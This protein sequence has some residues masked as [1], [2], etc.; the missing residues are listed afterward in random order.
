LSPGSLRR[1][2]DGA[3]DHIFRRCTES[4]LAALRHHQKVIIFWEA[5]AIGAG[6]ADAVFEL[7]S[8]I[9]HENPELLRGILVLSHFLE[10]RVFVRAEMKIRRRHPAGHWSGSHIDDAAPRLFRLAAGIG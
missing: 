4:L 7:A 6:N 5:A 3:A 1:R 2:Y 9:P 8:I 10:I